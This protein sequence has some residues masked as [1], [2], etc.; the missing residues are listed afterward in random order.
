VKLVEDFRATTS[1]RRT[2]RRTSLFR[3][4]RGRD[5]FRRYSSSTRRL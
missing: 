5:R 3:Y 2:V 1:T 4:D